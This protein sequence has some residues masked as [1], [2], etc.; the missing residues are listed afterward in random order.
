MKMTTVV[1]ASVYVLGSV[2]DALLIGI[3]NETP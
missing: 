1:I 3:Q 2:V